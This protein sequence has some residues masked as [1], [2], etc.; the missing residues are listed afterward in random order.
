MSA[1]AFTI[2]SIIKAYFFFWGFSKD[3]LKGPF[4]E[5]LTNDGFKPETL[6]QIENESNYRWSND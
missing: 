4:E 1:T 6:N 2:S 5:W 3:P